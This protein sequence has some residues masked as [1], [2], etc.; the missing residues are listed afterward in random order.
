[1]TNKEILPERVCAAIKANSIK[2]HDAD[3]FIQKIN[4]CCVVNLEDML[5][6]GTVINK[7]MIESPT[8]F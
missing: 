8:N 3:Y 4:N 1:M 6:N 2:F 5:D 7:R